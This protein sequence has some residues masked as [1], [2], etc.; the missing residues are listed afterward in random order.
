M[1]GFF[2]L[3][4]CMYAFLYFISLLFFPSPRY[5]PGLKHDVLQR[6]EK[7]VLGYTGFESMESHSVQNSTKAEIGL[8]L[9]ALIKERVCAISLWCLK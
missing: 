5:S 4:V 8:S 6:E 7:D 1:Q 9:L 3:Y 2:S